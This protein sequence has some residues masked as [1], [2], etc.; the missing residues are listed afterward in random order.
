MYGNTNLS[1]LFGALGTPPADLEAA[2][3]YGRALAKMGLPVLL[4]N[5][6][7]KVP[8]DWRSTAE[9]K[10]AQDAGERGGVHLATTDTRTL[11]KFLKRAYAETAKRGHP[12]PLA[13]GT[14]I[15][16]AVRLRGSGY[17]VA[18]AD[19]PAE[20][21]ALRAFLAQDYDGEVPAPTVVTPGTM[22]GAHSGGGHWWFRLPE[23]LAEALTPALGLQATVKVYAPGREDGAGF[24]LYMGDAYVLVPPSVRDG[25]G[26]TLTA[27]DTDLPPSL[28]ATIRDRLDVASA[29][30]AAREER[31]AEL[32]ARGDVP[33]SSLTMDEQITE[34]ARR[35]PWTE[36]LSGDRLTPDQRWTDTGVPDS[37]GCRV[38]TAPGPHGSPKSATTHSDVCT[39][40]NYSLHNAPMHIWTDNP[41]PELE[42][43]VE[44]HGRTLSK[45][46]VVAYLYH[47]GDESAALEEAG[48][49]T[50]QGTPLDKTLAA[51]G[52]GSVDSAVEVT[53]AAPVNQVDMSVL[54]PTP[55]V[56]PDPAEDAVVLSDLVADATT[57][58]PLTLTG[59]DP[60]DAWGTER[61]TDDNQ[62]RGHF[63]MAP[64]SQYAGMEPP[65]WL[66]D[67]LL[68]HGL[69]S[70]VGDSGV[71]KSAVVLDMLCHMA[72]GW[73]WRGRETRQC[74]SVYAAGESIHGA[75]DR[76]ATWA[77][78]HGAPEVLD[79]VILVSGTPQVSGDRKWW[80]KLTEGVLRTDAQVVVIDTLAR[81][82]VG[83]EENAAKDMGV[84]NGVFD[85][86]IRDTG[87]SLW[88]V[89]HVTRGTS[90]GRGSTALYG[91][92]DSEILIT[93][94]AEDGDLW[95][96]KNGKAVAYRPDGTPVEL[97]GKPLTV[98]ANK[99]KNGP[100]TGVW[101]QVLLSSVDGEDGRSHALVTELDGS[102]RHLFAGGEVLTS[103][104][105]KNAAR[106]QVDPEAW[107][108]PAVDRDQDVVERLADMV[109]AVVDSAASQDA[110]YARS[111]LS[112]MRSFR[113]YRMD[114]AR[115]GWDYVWS[116]HVQA[117][118]D[119]AVARKNNNVGRP[120]RATIGYVD[121]YDHD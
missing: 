26:Y 39:L 86:I 82:T 52:A 10:K 85:K 110:R 74:V 38:W 24:S 117:G 61:P 40:G 35:T 87:A 99:E 46:R 84:V 102:P 111:D 113:D 109:E 53:G 63:R 47:D 120:T 64:A 23:D 36:I 43:A 6:G 12:A 55:A 70:I 62:F 75:Y 106:P 60:Y 93:D 7:S 80:G 16:W 28:E 22:D 66:V 31:E 114:L 119:L 19:T 27:P 96:Q 32:E 59:V 115:Q 76:M 37:C 98:Q 88:Y 30:V 2:R 29:R 48:V 11:D 73:P 4:V 94:L 8:A 101:S 42:R 69:C 1:T 118:M 104:K 91:A 72:M 34:W 21:E 105:P 83:L 78:E 50:S 116:E 56:L 54:A 81:A 57:P 9:K 103:R 58:V 20:V 79:R 17:V 71:G 18:D 100:D 92:V 108:G 49:E 15:N 33:A 97:A 5:P 67:G 44:E 107:N 25:K 14:P 68:E 3:S 45:L 89:H 65:Q 51:V 112:T 95:D 77:R 41:G 13:P 90:H 121:P